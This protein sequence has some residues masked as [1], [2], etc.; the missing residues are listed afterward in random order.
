MIANNRVG[1]NHGQFCDH[2]PRCGLARILLVLVQLLSIAVFLAHDD[3]SNLRNSGAMS[4][5]P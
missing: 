5:Q 4:C 3:G 2:Q 1:K